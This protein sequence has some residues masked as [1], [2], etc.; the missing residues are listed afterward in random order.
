MLK[1][2]KDKE[3]ID[4]IV[5]EYKLHIYYKKIFEKIEVNPKLIG[6]EITEA[7]LMES[8]ETNEVILNE[9]IELWI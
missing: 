8:F 1:D 2:M 6:I 5:N 9:L 7:A 4:N 3:I